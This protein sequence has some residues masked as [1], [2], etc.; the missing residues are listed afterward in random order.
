MYWSAKFHLFLLAPTGALIVMVCYYISTTTFW[1]SVCLLFVPFC[2]S[3]PPEF[4]RSFFFRPP[5]TSMVLILLDHHYWMFLEGSTIGFDGFSMVF[6]ILRAMVNDGLEV[7]NGL[8]VPSHKKVRKI[9]S[10]QNA[11][12][13]QSTQMN[14][15]EH[16]QSWPIQTLHT[17]QQRKGSI[18]IDI[19]LKMSNI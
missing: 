7:N 18:S 15:S 9:N 10:R 14:I 4:L 19:G 8:H 1:E 12:F 3:V 6:E 16:L 13:K 17:V 11:N 2:R 5:L